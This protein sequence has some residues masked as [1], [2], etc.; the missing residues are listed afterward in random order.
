MLRVPQSKGYTGAMV[1]GLESPSLGT[2][3]IPQVKQRR[4]VLRVAVYAVVTLA[5]LVIGGF[6]AF[7]TYVG[8]LSQPDEPRADAIIVLTGGEARLDTAWQLLAQGKGKRLLISGVNRATGKN[9]LR[10]AVG[11][12]PKLFNCCVDFDYEALDTI[13]NATQSAQW[14]DN[15]RFGSAILVTNNYHMPRSLLELGRRTGAEL[16]A[17]PVVNTPL[18]KGRWLTER[19]ALRVL[20]TEY[21]KFVASA[22]GG[23]IRRVL[24]MDTASLAGTAKD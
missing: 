16:T 5:L 22:L 18:D 24:N 1:H 8:S 2:Q 19:A 23:D 3:T 14:L 20:V 12:D 6:G 11:A 10:A 21:L 15:H 4:R 13:G 7:A 17:F 9:Q